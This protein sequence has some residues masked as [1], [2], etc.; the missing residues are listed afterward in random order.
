MT[1]LVLVTGWGV[2]AERQMKGFLSLLKLRITKNPDSLATTAWAQHLTKGGRATFWTK[3]NKSE[4]DKT[5]RIN[6]IQMELTSLLGMGSVHL[7]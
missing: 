7:F 4:P 3:I 1:G 5:H 6:K 2:D